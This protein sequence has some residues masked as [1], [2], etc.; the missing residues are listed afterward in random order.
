M[1]EKSGYEKGKDDELTTARQMVK[2]WIEAEMAVMTGQEYR[3][4]TR[5]L[6]RADLREIGER[7]KYW[8]DEQYKLEGKHRIRV[9]QVIPRST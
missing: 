2:L 1:S 7:I 5:N 4:G 8:K 3:I 9:R 6:R